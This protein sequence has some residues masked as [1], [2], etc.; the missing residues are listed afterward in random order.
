MNV[1]SASRFHDEGVSTFEE[2]TL[3]LEGTQRVLEAARCPASFG[4]SGQSRKAVFE[5]SLL[6]A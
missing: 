3:A 6:R 1:A 5:R 2:G 4:S